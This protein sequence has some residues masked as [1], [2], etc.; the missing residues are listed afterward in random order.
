MKRRR[1]RS[2]AS[3]MGV[4]GF[5]TSC[6]GAA[7]PPPRRIAL[8][9]V[10]QGVRSSNTATP[11][12]HPG[13]AWRPARYRAASARG[14]LARAPAPPP[15]ATRA[16]SRRCRS[17]GSSRARAPAL[18][19][20]G[21]QRLAIMPRER[22][23]EDGPRWRRLA[24]RSTPS[25]PRPSR[26]RK[27]VQHRAQVGALRLGLLRCAGHAHIY[28]SAP[29]RAASGRRSRAGNRA[30]R[31]WPRAGRV[32]AAGAHRARQRRAGRSAPP[33]GAPRRGGEQGEQHRQQQQRNSAPG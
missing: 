30:R 28:I 15:R 11:A 10:E 4:S 29:A 2:A 21:A 18:M 5:F 31:G 26:R 16:P 20:D 12:R 1:R 6:A 27:D 3:W 17:S 25:G 9:A 7:R 33:G 13:R 8:G 22:H 14:A 23:A 24:V 32:M 19:A